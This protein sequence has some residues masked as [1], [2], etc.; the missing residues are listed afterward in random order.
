VGEGIIPYLDDSPGF[1]L[2]RLAYVDNV[3]AIFAAEKEARR[4]LVEAQV[5]LGGEP[6]SL[7]FSQTDMGSPELMFDDD[8]FSLMRGLEANPF[9]LELAF[10]QPRPVSGLEADFGLMDVTL[11]VT[12][13]PVLV[14]QTYLSPPAGADPLARCRSRPRR[15]RL[16]A[17]GLR[18]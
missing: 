16:P 12:L 6:V 13:Y 8:H 18:F 7:R 3:E 9:I 17:C 5:T 1:Y 15:R 4:Q 2:V 14:R 11:T 10:A